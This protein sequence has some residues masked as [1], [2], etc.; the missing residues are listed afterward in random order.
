[1]TTPGPTSTRTSVAAGAPRRPVLLRPRVAAAEIG[2]A[3]GDTA[4]AREVRRAL[5]HEAV[6][7]IA[8]YAWQLVWLGLRWRAR[9]RACARPGGQAAALL[10]ELPATTRRRSPTARSRPPSRPAAGRARRGLDGGDRGLQEG[11]DP[12]PSRTRCCARAR[13]VCGGRSRGASA[14]VQEAAR[15]AAAL[16]AA[17]LLAETHALRDARVRIEADSPEVETDGAGIECSA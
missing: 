1:M 4:G 11:R 17:P 12:T 2:R 15:L 5:E 14:A 3:L 8:R 13:C 6:A 7:P 9:L 10:R 16:G